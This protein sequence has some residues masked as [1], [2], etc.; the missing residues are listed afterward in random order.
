ML[1]DDE[2]SGVWGERLCHYQSLG[3]SY[4]IGSSRSPPENKLC[5]V[6]KGPADESARYCEL[7]KICI[8]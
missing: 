7:L 1:K 2:G 4:R 6:H 8:S 5:W 3:I